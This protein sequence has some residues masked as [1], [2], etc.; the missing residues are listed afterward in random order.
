MTSRVQKFERVV[1]N[2]GDGTTK[3]KVSVTAPEGSEVTVVPETLVFE[4]K[5]EKQ[6]YSLSIKYGWD[7]RGRVSF[8]AIVWVEENGNHAVRSPIVVSPVI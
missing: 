1:T 2:V 4:K 6:S 3:Y 5:N 7:S 8:G